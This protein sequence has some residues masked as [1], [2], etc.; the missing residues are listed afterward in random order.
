[1]HRAKG[2]EFP[3]TILADPSA[4]IAPTVPTRHVDAARRLWLEPLAGCTPVELV[5]NAEA[6]HAADV[7]EGVRLAYVAATRA[8]DLLV[9][10]AL[11]DG[12]LGGWLE[13]LAPAL[14]PA[15]PRRPV[16]VSGCPPFGADTVLERPPEAAHLAASAVVPGGH[17]AAA[18]GHAVVWWD[19]R[20]LPLDAPADVGLRGQDVLVKDDDG[21]AMA[22]AAAHRAWQAERRRVRAEAMRPTLPVRSL[23]E[24]TLIQRLLRQVPLDAHPDRIA[25]LARACGAAPAELSAVTARVAAALAHPVVAAAAR[26]PEVRRAVPVILGTGGGLVEGVVDLAYRAGDGW[27]VVG[28]TDAADLDLYVAAFAAATRAPARGVWIEL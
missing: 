14:T 13:P 21:V 18:G 23:G 16:P 10:P 20:A 27:I 19:P 8:R 9:V 1:V 2:L 17:E 4:P 26:A 28:W 24:G 15:S 11:G 22:A 12:P 5:E 25:D 6:A 7:A 3:V